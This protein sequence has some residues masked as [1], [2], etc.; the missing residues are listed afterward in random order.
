MVERQ[1]SKLNT[2]VRFPSPAPNYNNKHEFNCSVMFIEYY[3]RFL[4]ANAV[5]FVTNNKE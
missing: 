5:W 3:E 4:V 2:W 1:P